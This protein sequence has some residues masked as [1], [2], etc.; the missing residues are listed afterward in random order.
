MTSPSHPYEQLKDY[1]TGVSTHAYDLHETLV[2]WWEDPNS[3][4]P[5][6]LEAAVN[7]AHAI[8]VDAGFL[9]LYAYQ[10]THPEADH[11]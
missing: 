3:V 9:W 4:S 10:I 2:D 5:T 7:Q 11:D 6:A 8:M 1:L